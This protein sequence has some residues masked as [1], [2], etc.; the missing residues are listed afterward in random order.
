MYI[1]EIITVKG[2]CEF[3]RYC[4]TSAIDGTIVTFA[5]L[6]KFCSASVLAYALFIYM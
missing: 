1:S 5:K 6:G 2:F 3:D 4:S